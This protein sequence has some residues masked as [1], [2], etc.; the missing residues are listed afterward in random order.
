MQIS[1][2]KINYNKGLRILFTFNTS[3]IAFVPTTYS[4]A[5]KVNY[6]NQPVVQT[7]LQIPTDKKNQVR[8]LHSFASKKKGLN[9]RL[10]PSFYVSLE[11]QLFF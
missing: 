11:T 8:K 4:T 3:N 5:L 10:I 2:V 7:R 9:I 6:S 1:N